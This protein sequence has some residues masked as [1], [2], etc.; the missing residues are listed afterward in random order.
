MCGGESLFGK[1]F[2]EDESYIVLKSVY[3]SLNGATFVRKIY[4]RN[5]QQG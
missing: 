4:L 5:E 1:R 2:L 3:V